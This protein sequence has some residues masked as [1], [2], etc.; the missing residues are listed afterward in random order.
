MGKERIARSAAA[1]KREQRAIEREW[2]GTIRDIQESVLCR[3]LLVEQQSSVSET[4]K[5]SKSRLS[6]SPERS[7]SV[8]PLPGPIERKVTNAITHPSYLA[9]E[10]AKQV[11]QMKER[12]N[13]R[14]KLHELEYKPKEITPPT[15]NY[16]PSKTQLDESI[17]R[18]IAKPSYQTSQWAQ[19]VKAIKEKMDNRTKLC[20]ETYPPKAKKPHAMVEP[21][22][23]TG[24][25]TSELM[26]V[27]WFQGTA[28]A[29]QLG[30]ILAKVNGRER[31]HEITYP[32]K[33]EPP[34]PKRNILLEGIEARLQ[35]TVAVRRAE[36]QKG[37][38]EQRLKLKDACEQG[39]KSANVYQP[40]AYGTIETG[41]RSNPL[42]DK[43]EA[44]MAQ[45]VAE[46]R[47]EM[48]VA[49]RA[50]RKVLR[51]ICER[52]QAKSPLLALR[53]RPASAAR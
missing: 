37:E 38:K 48:V 17:E 51:E 16:A 39:R 29:Q 21:K 25:V 10:W 6:T 13:S 5:A 24:E 52:G 14:P 36:M 32:P 8:G 45:K 22:K 35:E 41:E 31:L 34:P 46:R 40:K 2:W 9:S 30:G 4:L 43:I 33:E 11:E 44:E 7:A 12:Q 47:K 18:A 1:R 23:C 3:P 15:Q 42:R 26:Q 53:V 49:D 28:Y 19:Q 20:D 50:Q 27:P